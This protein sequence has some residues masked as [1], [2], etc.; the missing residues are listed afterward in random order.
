MKNSI[1]AL[2]LALLLG[3][4]CGEK[5]ADIV[6]QNFDSA[7][8]QLRLAIRT[9]D[10]ITAARPDSLVTA[11]GDYPRVFPRS[12]RKD[13]SL[14]LIPS[15]DWTSGFFPGSLW[16]MYEYTGDTLWKKQAERFT[17]LLQREQFNR[18]T[19]DIGFI[20]ND[21]YGNGYRLTGNPAYKNVIVQAARTLSTRFNPNVGC[22]LSWNP[23]KGWQFPVIIDNMMNLELL[24]NATRITG[25]STF[26][27]IAVSHAD[28]TMKNHYRPDYSSYHVIDYD[29]LSGKVLHRNTPQGY[30][31]ASSWA[32]GQAWG[33]YGYTA[34]Y[35]ETGDPRYLEQAEKIAGRI[36]TFPNMPEDMIPYWDFDAP[37]IPDA[38]RDVS[39]ATIMASALYE[40]ST[41][42]TEQGPRYKAWAD[43]IIDNLSA[44]YLAPQG[45]N[46]GFLLLH[47]VGNLPGGSEI[48]TPLNYAD[49][50]FLEAL[51]RKRKCEIND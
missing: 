31:D 35:R 41:L 28:T 44:S 36:Y 48:D 27:R 24:M 7:A 5:K 32:R 29:S 4:C 22:I 18:N 30:A 45:S 40:L 1:P 14:F 20:I 11:Q 38:P 39:A 2:C 34:M 37:D 51:L 49:Y 26:Y 21:S 6:R 8:P 3:S 23:R 33:L 15:K 42:A 19:H 25:D 16:Y 9:A 50:Y 47:S 10:S 13:G 43:R 17:D 12:I 46:H